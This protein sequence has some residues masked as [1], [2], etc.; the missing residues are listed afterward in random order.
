LKNIKLYLKLTLIIS[1]INLPIGIIGTAFGFRDFAVYLILISVFL[2]D[3]FFLFKF[4]K[5]IKIN[6]IEFLLL[7]LVFISICVG[8]INNDFSRSFITDFINPIYFI[9][10]ICLFRQVFVKD[11]IREFIKKNI[12]IASKYLFIFSSLA[13]ILFYIFSY[14]IDIY[15]GSGLT[16]HPFL[17]LSILSGSIFQIIL[18]FLIVL[19][20]GKRALLLSSIIIIVYSQ[21][22]II[23]KIPLKFIII[24]SV[25]SF[26]IYSYFVID[27]YNYLSIGKYI[28]TYDKL[29]E[30]GFDFTLDNQLINIASAGRLGEIN[31]V[32]SKMN[33]V[34]FII[35]KGVGFKYDYERLDG[36][37]VSNYNNIHFTPL[38]LISKYG[39]IFFIF[40]SYYIFRNLKNISNYGYLN[41]FFG[42]YL[43]GLLMDMI[44]AYSI[45][46]DSFLPIAIAY[47]AIPKKIKIL[48]DFKNK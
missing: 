17:I 10:K 21:I 43:I 3:S 48:D 47:L 29:I 20:S 15:V 16:T 45:F 36:E 12:S 1:L 2:L 25:F 46:I 24:T 22:K 4:F 23:K 18:V 37:L 35:G 6:T 41:V 11:E 14:Y 30:S 31:A 40:L 38:S 7:S 28:W 32:A 42:L 19:A 34:D 44:F 33:F 5:F 39:L 13:L 8:L 26:S 9:L 27:F